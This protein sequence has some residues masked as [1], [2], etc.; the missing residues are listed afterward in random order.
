MKKLFSSCFLFF[1]VVNVFSQSYP[2][3]SIPDN[4]K[5]RASAVIRTEQCLYTISKS[6]NAV[7]KVKVAITLLSEKSA[8]YRF[9]KVNYDKES[10]VNYLKG[11]IYD[12]KGKIIKTLGVFDV[13]DMSAI[14]GASFYSDDRMKLLYYPLYKYPYTIEFEYEKEYSTTYCYPLWYFHP[15]PGVSV[16]KSGIQMVVPTGMNLRYITSNLKNAADSVITDDSKIYTWQE[17]NLPVIILRNYSARLHYHLPYLNTA[18]LDFDYGGFK[19]SMSSWKTFGDWVY[20]LNKGRDILPQSELDKVTEITSKTSDTR[21]RV[22]LIYEY[23]QSKTRYVS[24][25]IGIGGMRPAEASSVAKNGFG[26]CKALVNYT[27]ALLKAA[28]IKSYYTLVRAGGD[29]TIYPAFVD[30]MFDH[31]ILCVPMQKDTVWLECTNQTLPF[32]YLGG[33]TDDRYVLLITPEGGKLVRTPCFTKSENVQKRTGSV[34]LNV[35][36]ASSG[37]ISNFYSGLFFDKARDQ[38]GL[39]S[40]L[41]MKQ[42]LSSS[43]RFSNFNVSSV[44]YSESKS[45]K[46]SATFSYE[47]SVNDFATAMGSRIYFSPSIDQEEFQQDFPSSVEISDPKIVTDSIIYYLPIGYKTQFLPADVKLENEFGEFR[48]YLEVKDD[49]LIYKR[50]LELNKANIPIE[51]FY[52][53]RSF[54]NTVAK[55]DR[56]RIILTKNT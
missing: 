28:D 15:N 49:R 53:F 8:G 45:E 46:P 48:Y 4:L 3:D 41:E 50:Y 20:Q 7:E 43:L 52:E 10:K 34:F 38:F 37:K 25:Q 17:E 35:L 22:K 14:T 47:I 55:A 56:E 12:E 32:N 40:E 36:G 5:K 1:I 54:I 30:D 29:G 16:E 31:V 9:M 44:N 51:K 27:M 24:I 13:Y 19:G 39:Q 42:D 33:F 2:F 21:E 6:G 23:M 11:A 26:D 18:P